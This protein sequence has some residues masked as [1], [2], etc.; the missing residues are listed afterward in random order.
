LASGVGTNFAALANAAQSEKIP[1]AEIVALVTNRPNA[2]VLKIAE[3][4]GIPRHIVPSEKYPTRQA[5]EAELVA[6]LDKLQP[7][8][9]CL[10]GYLMLLGNDVVSRWRHRILNIH[11][12]LLPAFR[13]LKAQKQAL[14]YG[15][16]WTG[17]TV[18]L[19]TEDLDGGPIVAQAPIEILPGENEESLSQRL[20]AVE[21]V[22]YVLGLA[23][24][25]SEPYRIEGRRIVFKP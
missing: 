9:I 14:D 7:D 24:L 19:V 17:C 23:R 4:L 21:N 13:G 3:E 5:Y 16:T 12:S 1:H 11:P 10:A 6:L 2:P 8:F 25:C 22:T 18:H 20:K 15:V